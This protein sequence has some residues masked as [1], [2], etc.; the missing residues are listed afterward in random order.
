MILPT[1][2]VA[3][4]ARCPHPL[5]SSLPASIK[6]IRYLLNT[7]M[8]SPSLTPLSF[9]LLAPGE[10]GTS[11]PV[12]TPLFTLTPIFGNNPTDAWL[13]PNGNANHDNS[14][15]QFPNTVI[16]KSNFSRIKQTM[17]FIKYFQTLRKRKRRRYPTSF[18]PK[19]NRAFGNPFA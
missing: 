19:I 10:G 16:R 4:T 8:Q 18:F 5:F 12:S 3:H 2:H 1:P 15:S 6:L 13:K 9:P 7:A 14:P 11:I 17:I